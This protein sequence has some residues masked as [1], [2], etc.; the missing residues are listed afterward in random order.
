MTSLCLLCVSLAKSIAAAVGVDVVGGVGAVVVVVVVIGSV[1]VDV[2]GVAVA[3][4]VVGGGK[5][6][7]LATSSVLRLL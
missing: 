5:K 7:D 3:A 2:G 6:T 4:A 1:D